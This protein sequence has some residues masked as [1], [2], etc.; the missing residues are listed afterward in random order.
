MGDRSNE[1]KNTT[2]QLIIFV[3]LVR[4]IIELISKSINKKKTR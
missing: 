1:Q 4:F 2:M 3:F